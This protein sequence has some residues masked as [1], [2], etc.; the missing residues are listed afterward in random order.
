VPRSRHRW[1]IHLLPDTSSWRSKGTALLLPFLPIF[2]EYIFF[3]ILY[4]P[5]AYISTHCCQAIT[6]EI[7]ITLMMETE[8]ISVTLVF[9][10]TMTRLIAREH[11]STYF[12]CSESFKFYKRYRL[13]FCIHLEN[14]PLP[15][16][17][18]TYHIETC[19]E[20]TLQILM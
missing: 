19:V 16:S 8:E 13:T 6:I 17:L 2:S 3:T 11:F 15:V 4:I 12:E 9:N 10:S 14:V 7:N 5:L 20:Q 18:N 1:S